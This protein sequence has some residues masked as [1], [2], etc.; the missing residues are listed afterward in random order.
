M[1]E[2]TIIGTP[3]TRKSRRRRKQA[4]AHVPG[5]LSPLD[6]GAPVTLSVTIEGEM[7]AAPIVD[8]SVLYDGGLDLE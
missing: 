5:W 2:Q 4:P 3:T 8:L 7:L 1:V 6:E